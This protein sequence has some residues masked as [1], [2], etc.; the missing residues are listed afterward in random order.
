[1]VNPKFLILVILSL[2]LCGVVGAETLSNTTNIEEGGSAY[3][4]LEFYLCVVVI[5]FL[6]FFLS[7]MI[8]RSEDITGIIA[9]IFFAAA[10]LLTASVQFISIG[11]TGT[12]TNPI[13]TPVA[14]HPYIPYVSYIW[15]MMFLVCII[16]IYR[17]WSNRFIE[18]K[19]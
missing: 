9:A 16:N 14:Y 2:L 15:G 3:I 18:V 4:P 11:Y 19:E 17:I 10:A 12:I 13:I 1:M 6:F 8:E 7:I 5:A